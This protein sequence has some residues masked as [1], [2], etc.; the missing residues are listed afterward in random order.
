MG[1]ERRV[2]CKLEHRSLKEEL[3]S[4]VLCK[5]Y[6]SLYQKNWP[7]SEC[8]QSATAMSNQVVTVIKILKTWMIL[9]GTSSFCKF[10]RGFD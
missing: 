9:K 7:V 10:V 5:K 3:G 4:L 6:L 1:T 2:L 8:I